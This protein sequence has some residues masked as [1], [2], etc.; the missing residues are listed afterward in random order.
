LEEAYEV[1]KA[2]GDISLFEQEQANL[3]E[4]VKAKEKET[5][6]ATQEAA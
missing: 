4:Q 1:F 6:S 5:A 3:D 2:T